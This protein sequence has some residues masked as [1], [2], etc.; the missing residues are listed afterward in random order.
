MK[1][2]KRSLICLLL[3]V[4]LCSSLFAVYANAIEPLD[5][6]IDADDDATLIKP[7][8]EVSTTPTGAVAVGHHPGTNDYY[9]YRVNGSVLANDNTTTMTMPGYFPSRMQTI[10][11]HEVI[12]PNQIIGAD[13][14]QKITDAEEAPYSAICLMEITFPNNKTYYGTAFM[15]SGDT[16]M[17]AAHCL[18]KTAYGGW[19]TSVTLYPGK[20]G[21]GFFN[22]PFGTAD[23]TEIVVS[24][25][26]YY[27]PSDNYEN[28]WGFI[29]L[30]DDIGSD[31]GY[32]GFRYVHSNIQNLSL[33]MCGY[34]NPNPNDPQYYQYKAQGEVYSASEQLICH[35]VD[36]E[37]GQSGSPLYYWDSSEGAYIVIG[38]HVADGETD[39]YNE[40][41]RI[42]SQL[43]SFAYAYR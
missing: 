34:P 42:T 21:Y 32:L 31:S 23:A 2:I 37:G 7:T 26:Y 41:S 1:K 35:T 20:S 11:E 17:T 39:Y 13:N 8:L 16:A 6:T 24:A 5:G 25:N 22:N 30:D 29:K 14:R 9:Y 3:C 15:I 18:Y 19:A 27:D 4:C 10:N 28:D 40:A 36:G 38:V 12:L 43:F 33:Y